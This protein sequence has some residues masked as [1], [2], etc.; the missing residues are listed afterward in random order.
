[1]SW[2]ITVTFCDVFKK[3]GS[4]TLM[5]QNVLHSQAHYCLLFAAIFIMILKL[6]L[7]FGCCLLTQVKGVHQQVFKYAFRQCIWDFCHLCATFSIFQAN[8]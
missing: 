3:S 1:M 8:K 6:C 2:M 4:S 5:W 7:M